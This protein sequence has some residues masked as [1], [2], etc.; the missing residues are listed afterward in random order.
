MR[1]SVWSSDVCSSDLPLSKAPA[2]PAMQNQL[3]QA[4]GLIRSVSQRLVTVLRVAQAIVDSQTEFFEHGIQAMR[5]LLLRDIAPDL[6]LHESTVSRAPTPQN[7]QTT[8]RRHLM[9][10]ML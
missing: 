9:Q 1:I 3:A 5:P 2:A 7:V 10:T 4:H 8:W 6:Q